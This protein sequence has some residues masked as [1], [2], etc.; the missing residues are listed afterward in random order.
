VV[1]LHTKK[2]CKVSSLFAMQRTQRRKVDFNP[3]TC[4]LVDVDCCKLSSVSCRLLDVA[5]IDGCLSVCGCRVSDAGSSV[6]VIT[7]QV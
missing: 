5:V 2:S 4:I 6:S 7:L 1:I 3:R